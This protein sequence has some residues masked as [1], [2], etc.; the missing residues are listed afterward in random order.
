MNWDEVAR[1]F[2]EA[3]TRSE[4]ESRPACKTESDMEVAIDVPALVLFQIPATCRRT[5]RPMRS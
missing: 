5:M 3:Q 2:A 1:R 4:P